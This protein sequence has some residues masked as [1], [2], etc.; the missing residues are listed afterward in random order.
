[1]RA[2]T[3]IRGRVSARAGGVG[4]GGG[5]GRA[6]T[7]SRAR[8]A[9]HR[10]PSQEPFRWRLRARPRRARCHR[11][12][13]PPAGRPAPPSA[14]RRPGGSPLPCGAGSGRLSSGFFATFSFLWVCFER[15]GVRTPVAIKSSRFG[16]CTAM[17]RSFTSQHDGVS[18]VPRAARP[19]L[20]RSWHGGAVAS[21]A[22]CCR[23]TTCGGRAE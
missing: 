18:R 6:P 22:I 23:G 14:L 2:N 16:C 7:S 5:A 10:P 17:V 12:G 4:R 8:R 11:R 3:Q 13:P 19:I 15:R 9:S 20:A 1:M 21:I